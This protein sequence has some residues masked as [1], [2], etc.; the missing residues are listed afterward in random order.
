MTAF[1]RCLLLALLLAVSNVSSAQEI[2]TNP[3]TGRTSTLPI[4]WEYR[5]MVSDQGAQI[6]RFRSFV[7]GYDVLVSAEPVSNWPLTATISDYAEHLYE[8]GAL[9][10]VFIHQLTNGDKTIEYGYGWMIPEGHPHRYALFRTDQ[11]WRVMVI[12]PRAHIDD[13]PLM[14]NMDIVT[15]ITTTF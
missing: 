14:Q 7:E 5:N 3:V 11:F 15:A 9:E 8:A 6:S 2:Y 13:I 12:R 4:G 1:A 10:F